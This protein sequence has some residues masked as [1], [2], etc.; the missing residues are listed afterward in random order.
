MSQDKEQAGVSRVEFAA[1]KLRS[2]VALHLQSLEDAS[3]NCEVEF[4]AALHG[5]C[6]FVTLPEKEAGQ[7]GM[8]TG[9]RYKVS[10]FNGTCEFAFTSAILQIQLKPFFHVHLAYPDAIEIRVVRGAMREKLSIAVYAMPEGAREGCLGMM[11]DLSISGAMIES[12]TSW[13]EVGDKVNI[14]FTTQFEAKKVDLK[15]PAVIR[16]NSKGNSGG[17]Y[18][19]GLEF[20]EVGQN[21]KLILYYLL[22]TLSERR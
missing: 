13:G 1:L 6:I 5:K 18:N 15:I 22:F 8:Q 9:N 4:A 16:H 7:R 17:N 19:I 14:A 20:G 2:G 10:G 12:A 3:R 21:D 11:K